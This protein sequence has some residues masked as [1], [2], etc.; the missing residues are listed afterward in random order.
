MQSKEVLSRNCRLEVG[1]RSETRGL[2]FKEKDLGMLG[3][4]FW[5]GFRGLGKGEKRMAMKENEDS[6]HVHDRYYW[7]KIMCHDSSSFGPWAFSSGALEVISASI[8][9]FKKNYKFKNLRS[10]QNLF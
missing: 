5:I 6:Y 7:R 1:L 8:L 10:L 4:G 2:G 9:I 3:L